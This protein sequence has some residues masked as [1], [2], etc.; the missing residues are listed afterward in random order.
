MPERGEILPIGKGRMIREG[1]KVAIL[2]KNCAW[3]MMSDLAIWMAG[4]VSVPLY[5][6]LAPDTITQILHHSESKA[7]FIGKLDHVEVCFGWRFLRC[8]G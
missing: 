8:R 4:Y 3:W 2:S 6:T 5:P 7:C 1:S